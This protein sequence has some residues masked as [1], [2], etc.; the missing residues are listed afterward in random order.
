MGAP[1]SLRMELRS[2][3]PLPLS[4]PAE[5][6]AL[7]GDGSHDGEENTATLLF[8][9]SINIP[10][11]QFHLFSKPSQAERERLC[12]AWSFRGEMWLLPEQ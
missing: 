12:P 2:I 5:V 10:R 7:S 6:K 1:A 8:I 9:P 3:P 4:A 11:L